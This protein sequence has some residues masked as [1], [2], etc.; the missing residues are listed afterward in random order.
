MF[1]GLNQGIY[2]Y[3]N[4]PI[5]EALRKISNHGFK[6]IDYST[7]KSS[8]P[9]TM[10]KARHDEVIRIFKGEQFVCSQLLMLETK[11]LAIAEVK[12][13]TKVL[14]YMKRSA[15]FQIELGG[16]HVLI[17]WGGGIQPFSMLKEQAWLNSVSVIREFCHWAQKQSIIASIEMDPHVYFVVN[18]LYKMVKIIEDVEMPNLFANIDIGHLCITREEPV[19]MEKLSNKIL[20][21]HLSDT[22][23]FNHTSDIL[24][25]G[26]ANFRNYI[27]KLLEIGIEENCRLSN[28]PC[29]ATIEVGARGRVDDPDRW[30]RESLS[31][32]RSTVPEL[33]M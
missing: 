11:D 3:A 15:E 32:I 4:I 25:T 22:D 6:Y 18:N 24:G 21:V 19:R 20:H 17:C 1:L 31:H 29:V 13:R 30:I 14:D 26:T 27:S 10:S 28:E 9:T 2:E 7:K 16:R 5:E 33:Q 12:R 23:S 8:D